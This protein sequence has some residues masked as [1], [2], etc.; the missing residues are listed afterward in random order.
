MLMDK[1][2]IVSNLKGLL[3]I[4]LII[5]GKCRL[6]VSHLGVKLL[7]SLVL[8]DRDEVPLWLMGG[9]KPCWLFILSCG[10]LGVI[11]NLVREVMWHGA[12]FLRFALG[13]Q[14]ASKCS[15]FFM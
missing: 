8:E 1:F 2:L 15:Y 5:S 12:C 13:F 6:V 3:A 9:A 14:L 7:C 4:Y 11:K 10:L